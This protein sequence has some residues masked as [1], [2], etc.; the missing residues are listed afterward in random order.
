MVADLKIDQIESWLE[1]Q[2]ISAQGVSQ[3][4]AMALDIEKWVLTG[5]ISEEGKAK[6]LRRAQAIA[7][8]NHYV[9]VTVLK[10]DGSVLFSSA[11]LEAHPC[12]PARAYLD[13]ALKLQTPLFTSIHRDETLPGQPLSL[14]LVAPMMAVDASGSRAVAIM[15]LRIDPHFFL[16]PLVQRWPTASLTAET[17]LGER[18]GREVIFLNE[19]RHRKGMALAFR[20]PIS[21]Q[22]RLVVQ[23]AT[24]KQGIL[25]GVDYRG[26]PV[27]GVA[28][29]ISG[30]PWVMIAKQD[31]SELFQSLWP[32]TLGMCLL[33][34]LIVVIAFLAVWSWMRQRSSVIELAG[35]ARYKALFESMG[36]ALMV[37]GPD[38]RFWDVNQIACDRLGYTREE[39]L[40][41]GPEDINSPES[42]PLLANAFAQLERTGKV[43]LETQHI[44]KDGSLIPVEVHS[45]R[46][47]LDGQMM[48]ISSVRDVTER[49]LVEAE[50]RVGQARM[51]AVF[52]NSGVGIGITDREGRFLVFNSAFLDFIGYTS[53]EMDGLCGA[54]ITHPDELKTS[55][56]QIQA[57]ERGEISRFSSETRYIRK[58]GQIRWGLLSVSPIRDAEGEIQQLIGMVSDITPRKQ[59]EAELAQAIERLSLA[60]K[61][62]GIGI[63]D[64][65]IVKNELVWD[66]EMFRLY[67]LRREDFSGAYEAWVKGL[68][69]EDMEK[70]NAEIQAALRGER[71]FAMEFRVRWPDGSLHH[72]KAAAKTLRDELGVPLRMVGIN[73]DIT[74]LKQAEEK[75]RMEEERLRALMGLHEASARPER[76]L[77]EIAI[78]EM[79]KLTDSQ[80]SYLHFVNA[81]QDTLELVA[82]NS[83][84]LKECTAVKEEH[85]PLSK[86]GVWADCFRLR[87]PAIHNDY[88]N[89]ADRHGYP[90]GH[91]HLLNHL[92]VP[93]FDGDRVVAIAGVGN[94]SGNYRDEDA[95]QLTLFVG[96]LWNLI[97]RKRAEQRL[98]ENEH[99][100]KTIADAMPGMVGYWTRE[101]RCTFANPQYLAWFG[102]SPEEMRNISMPELM[103]EERFAANEPYVRKALAGE[104][105]H[106]ER[107][108]TWP[109]GTTSFSLAHYIP[110]IAEDQVRGFFVLV[111]DITDV[112]LAQLQLEKLN[113]DLRERTRQAESASRAKSEF[114]ANMSHEIRTPMNAIMGLSHLVLRTPLAPK[115]KDY[116]TRIQDSSRL[117]LGIINDIL[118]ISKIE[119]GK[120]E[121]EHADFNL[122][123]VFD[124]IA[125]TVA[126]KAREKGLEIHFDLPL[127]I[128]TALV[129]DSLRLGQ[130]LLNLASNAVKFTEQGQVSVSVRLMERTADRVWLR[131]EI[132][133]SG[134]GISQEALSRLF[135]SFHQADT[136]TTRRYGGTGLGL[137]ICKRLVDLMG[138]EISVQSAVDAGSTFSFA[139]PF[140]L[141]KSSPAALAGLLGRRALVVDNDPDAQETLSNL[142]AGLGLGVDSL[143]S[144]REALERLVK[145]EQTPEFVLLDWRMPDMDGLELARAIQRDSRL[146]PKP[147]LVLVTAYGR[148]D[149]QKLAEEAGVDGVLLKPITPSLLRDVLLDALANRNLEQPKSKPLDVE[150]G[151]RN[152]GRIL[153]AEDNETNRIVAQEMLESAGFEVELACNGREAVEKA[154]DPALQIRLVLMDV[155]MP[156]MD[157]LEA[158]A[159]IR[160]SLKDLPIVAMTAHALDSERQR[161][162]DAGMNDHIPKPFEP[163]EVWAALRRWLPDVALDYHALAEAPLAAHSSPPFLSMLK[164]DLVA[165]AQA[166]QAACEQ[167]NPIQAGRAAHSLKGILG[168]VPVPSLREGAR[169]LDEAIRAGA[170]WL[171]L[172]QSLVHSLEDTLRNL[173]T[174]VM[175]ESTP[176]ATKAVDPE[177]LTALLQDLQRLL[178]RNSLSARKAMEALRE[179][180]GSDPRLMALEDCVNRMDFKGGLDSLAELRKALDL[181]DT[182]S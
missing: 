84:A 118:D 62:L 102:R 178:A 138:G 67:G 17:L 40:N 128:P 139:V 71:E 59:V 100:L 60:T 83:E 179:M 108:L 142:L 18:Q 175:P 4:T 150:E 90:E 125:G 116:L 12:L 167:E 121:I 147:I 82:W 122:R 50:V 114:L 146:A 1:F 97:R 89:L 22:T 103:G 166:I 20:F 49:K 168:V 148:E 158:T 86:A 140:E 48:H 70:G 24:G 78:E 131:F 163:D 176:K 151:L 127:E 145:G 111:S 27:M 88:S 172:A 164:R 10:R 109:N 80:I 8:I 21:D 92:S 63:W 112:K 95:K 94:K 6:W 46:L 170:P 53:E 157:G 57:L 159:R 129:G 137:A 77:I 123:K 177:V 7:Q 181:S 30:T 126:E 171:E 156:E 68:A 174:P 141:Q 26:V 169:A 39:L 29:S 106:F 87:R 180:L 113:A 58:D 45:S 130:V 3:G 5:N 124:H 35:Q 165:Q 93:I 42:G 47:L 25:E 99:F 132:R 119:A 161:C 107:T 143:G 117:L 52:E 160:Q 31:R 153:V 85:Y 11:G 28:R 69:S 2:K 75:Q 98:I 61:G 73:F 54:D 105:Q 33:T 38:R 133:D 76:E 155:Q 96:G 36:D 182:L 136:S 152:R 55:R 154:L 134:I 64:W 74:T 41:M 44:R 34:L 115:Q 120:L 65:D 149:I 13:D 32:R 16:Y 9:D 23:A 81:D 37:V 79:T 72:I 101:M 66:D 110:D 14:D 51:R 19:L 15:V 162:L 144:G 173:P 56:Q 135:Q 43:I 104:P 91:A